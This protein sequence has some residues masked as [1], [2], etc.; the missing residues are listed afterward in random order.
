MLHMLFIYH[1]LWAVVLITIYMLR[2]PKSLY[3]TKI[4]LLTFRNLYIYNPS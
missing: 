1:F 3:T 2:K 4:S